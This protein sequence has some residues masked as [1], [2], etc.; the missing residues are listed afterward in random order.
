MHLDQLYDLMPTLDT[1]D[2]RKTL[3]AGVSPLLLAMHLDRDI[4]AFSHMRYL[5]AHVVALCNLQL[6]QD[7]PGEAPEVYIREKEGEGSWQHIGTGFSA[8]TSDEAFDAE[9]LALIRPGCCHGG[10]PHRSHPKD[11]VVLKLAI[12]LPPRHGKSLLVTETL[13]LWFLL[14]H[15]SNAVVVSTYNQDFADEWGKNLQAKM[16][17]RGHLLPAAS[18]GQALLPLDHTQ[19]HMSFR[20]GK[21]TG[22]I[23]FR[24]VGR[25]LT[26]MAW[27]L[28]IIDDP[29]KDAAEAMSE[30]ERRNKKNWYSS[31]FSNRRTYVRGCPPPLE[32][33]MFTRWHEDDLAGAFAYEEDGETPKAGWC[34]L[35]LPALAEP[36]D[37]LGRRPEQSLC[38]QL[39][40]QE[41]LLSER[42]K[43]PTWFSCLFQGIPT[44]QTGSMFAKTRQKPDL[45][46][47]YHHHRP[48]ADGFRAYE[49]E[50]RIKDLLFYVTVDTAASKKT[51]AD[52]T[53]ASLWG[54]DRKR[55]HLILV[56]SKRERMSTDSHREWLKKFIKLH[57]ET[58][59]Q[60]VGIEDKTFGT[61][62]INEMRANEP[63]FTIIPLPVDKDKVTHAVPYAE[64]VRGARVFFPHPDT[65]F[66]SVSWENEHAKFPKGTHDDQ[67]D[68]GSMAWTLAQR[69]AYTPH[70]QEQQ[71]PPEPTRHQKIRKQLARKNGKQSHD[72][73]ELLRRMNES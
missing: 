38:P 23:N 13:P 64:A 10:D 17:Q 27:G 11:R 66:G 3:L 32:I 4:K 58:P 33:M 12:A 46:Y 48:S 65:W 70:E 9:E 7:G 42:E 71:L 52:Y 26:G 39:A 61:N 56:D 16:D 5:D 55:G 68:T 49:T 34:V 67:V 6:Y 50:Y 29:F 43:D 31:V 14:R 69:Y 25:S 51:S 47:A 19:R 53:V 24:G 72:Y 41:F 54:W 37:P 44:H 63:D 40:P 36:N 21:D 57:P 15:P 62:L 45:T 35:R 18:D 59:P 28:G 60:F 8:A 22:I 2:P 1:E 20:P 73:H 30:A